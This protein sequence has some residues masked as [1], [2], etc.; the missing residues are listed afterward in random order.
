MENGLLLRGE[1]G[2]TSESP[3]SKLLT[4]QRLPD[5]WPGPPLCT[6]PGQE[7]A[8]ISG[9]QATR[10]HET[11]PS[12]NATF[13]SDECERVS[14]EKAWRRQDHQ[15]RVLDLLHLTGDQDLSCR[16]HGARATEATQSPRPTGMGLLFLCSRPTPAQTQVLCK[17]RFQ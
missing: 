9:F 14:A 16:T 4:S 5:S 10:A 6:S 12:E 2:P 11:Q 15:H 1:H 3:S 13:P 17:R 8:L 7:L